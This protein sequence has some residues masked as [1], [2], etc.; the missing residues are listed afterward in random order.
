MSGDFDVYA[1][2]EEMLA[3]A[4]QVIALQDGYIRTTNAQNEA[5]KG[6]FRGD[7]AVTGREN[8]GEK[9]RRGK[10]VAYRLYEDLGGAGDV[11]KKQIRDTLVHLLHV[12]DWVERDVRQLEVLTLQG[13]PMERPEIPDGIARVIRTL[14]AGLPV[15]PDGG[16]PGELSPPRE[17]PQLPMPSPP[18]PPP[19]SPTIDLTG[20]PPRAK[21]SRTAG[22]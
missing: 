15:L 16:A 12:F 7:E 5:L 6:L 1:Y 22:D 4:L 8:I 18:P 20:S 17:L 3:Q 11:P 9:C 21:R 14:R 13:P 10:R 2:Q 19:G